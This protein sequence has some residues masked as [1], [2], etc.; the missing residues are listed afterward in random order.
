MMNAVLNSKQLSAARRMMGNSGGYNGTGSILSAF[1]QST[2]FKHNIEYDFGYPKTEELTFNMFYAM[3]KRHGIAHALTERTTGKTWQTFPQIQEDEQTQEEETNLETEIRRHFEKIRFWQKLQE[4]DMRSMVGKYSAVIFRLGDGKRFNEPVDTVPGGI[5]GLVEV[6]PCWE[7][8]LEPSGWDTNPDSENYGK[9][10]MYRFNESAVDSEKGKVRS[11]MVHPDRVFIWSRDGT[12]W[13]D[14]K[15][16][17]C[18]NALIDIEKIRGAG[19]EGFWKNAKA[20]PVL[21]AD[22]DVDFTQLAAALGVE[23]SE[24][25]DALDEVMGKWSKGFDESLILQGMKATTL[26]VNLPVPEHFYSVAL[27]E[28]AASWPIP[29]KVLVGMQTGERASTEDSKEWAQINMG[30]RNSLVEPMINEMIDRLESWGI[31]EERDWYIDWDDLTAPSLDE[32]LAIAERMAKVNQAMFATGETV[33]TENEIREIAG[34]GAM[35][36]MDL[37]EPLELDEEDDLDGDD[38]TD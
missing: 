11:F 37:S 19:G 26:S 12:T 23:I 4:T 13:G 18:F 29:Q 32:K 3:W 38:P 16:E 36:E 8:Q 33:F 28:V 25:P 10:V 31:L 2:N 15:L 17:S 30:R 35:E 21:E 27:Q 6:I 14:S 22:A 24:L 20:Q 34:Y 7:G 5:E 9:P 1:S